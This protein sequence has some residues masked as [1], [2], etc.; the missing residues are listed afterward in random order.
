MP[1]PNLERLEKDLKMY[2]QHL[3]ETGNIETR[4]GEL[5]V[6]FVLG[7]IYGEYQRCI[8]DSIMQRVEKLGDDHITQYVELSMKRLGMGKHALQE[9]VYKA[10][11]GGSEKMQTHISTGAWKKYNKLIALRNKAMHGEEVFVKLDNVLEI[12]HKAAEVVRGIR[13]TLAGDEKHDPVL[14][15]GY[16]HIS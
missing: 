11:G 7:L 2:V 15:Q 14:D 12:H 6:G 4:L 8:R 9:N 1:K 16:R 3:K 10:F 5:S 13:D